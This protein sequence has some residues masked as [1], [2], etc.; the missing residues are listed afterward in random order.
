MLCPSMRVR[1]C[2]AFAWSIL[3][4]AASG[5]RQIGGGRADSRRAEA[6][7]ERIGDRRAIDVEKFLTIAQTNDVPVLG[8]QRGAR[9]AGEVAGGLGVDG[10]R[11]ST[12][13]DARSGLS[14]ALSA[15]QA[16][17]SRAAFGP[18]PQIAFQ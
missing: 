1:L 7:V 8:Q 3:A 11:A 15:V 9:G 10:V 6:H 5:E 4:A 16:A 14:R 17:S 18:A 12:T 2:V 13:Q